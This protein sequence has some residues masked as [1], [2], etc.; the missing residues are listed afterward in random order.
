MGCTVITSDAG[1]LQ[2]PIKNARHKYNDYL[3]EVGASSTALMMASYFDGSSK[4][5][6]V[7]LIDEGFDSMYIPPVNLAG[8]EALASYDGGIAVLNV[9]NPLKLQGK[10]LPLGVSLMHELGHAKQF[11]EQPAWFENHYKAATQRGNK[12]SQLAI[13]ND[14]VTRHEMPICKELSLPF[15]TKYD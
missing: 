13:E 8:V 6:G 4:N 12:E 3:G 1:G 5:I 2:A 11:I 15:R 9:T 10:T 7:L 14:N